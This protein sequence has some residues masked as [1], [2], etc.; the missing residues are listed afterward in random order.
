MKREAPR[1]YILKSVYWYFG[2]LLFGCAP[3]IFLAMVY[4]ASEGKLGFDDMQKLI[5]EGAILFVCVAMIGSVLVDFLQSE[6]KISGKQI[7][8]IVLAPISSIG[9]LFLQYLFVVLKIINADCLNVTSETSVS[10]LCF[11]LVY[12]ILNKTNLLIMEDIK[13]ELHNI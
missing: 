1:G 10:I 3:I 5:H 9:F 13:Y 11:S 4:L 7:I 2:N 12:C 6:I 8:I